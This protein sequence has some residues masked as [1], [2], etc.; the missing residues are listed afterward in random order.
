LYT[1]TT[2]FGVHLIE[3]QKKV[4][5]TQE[6]KY[7]AAIISEPIVPSQATQEAA[8]DKLNKIL[9]ANRTLESLKKAADEAGLTLQSSN[10]LKLNDYIFESFGGGQTSRDI[11]KWAHSAEIGEVAPMVYEY[12]DN[13]NY[14]SNAYTLV[15][16]K[17]IDP[18]GLMSVTAAKNSIE[19]LVRNKKK[20]EEILKKLT[21]STIEQMATAVGIELEEL[22]SVNYV[23]GSAELAGEPKVIATI[24]GLKEGKISKPIIGSTGVYVVKAETKTPGSALNNMPFMRQSITSNNRMMLP[25]TIWPAIKATAKIKDNRSRFY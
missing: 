16:L 2:Q 7:K 20:G 8:F 1:V 15:G 5:N 3:V 13:V 17:Q 11:I 21:G 18:A 24:S 9:T 4:F 12:T 14:Y 23:S 6:P 22:A 19:T 25:Y 10:P